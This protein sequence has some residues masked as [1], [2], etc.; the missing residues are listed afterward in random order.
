M[1]KPSINNSETIINLSKCNNNN[2]FNIINVNTSVGFSHAKIVSFTQSGLNQE[3]NKKTNQ[4]NFIVLTNVLKSL[5]DFMIFGVFDGHGENGHLISLQIKLFLNDYYDETK[6]YEYW[7]KIKHK[8]EDDKLDLDNLQILL[9]HGN[10]A[11]IRNCITHL[12]CKIKEDY[13][14]ISKESGSTLNLLFIIGCKEIISCNIGDSRSIAFDLKCLNGGKSLIEEQLTID[15]K[16]EAKEE[17][18]RISN[19]N[20]DVFRVCDDLGNYGPYRVFQKGTYYPGLAMSRSI[21]DFNY[22]EIGI[23]CDPDI[24]LHS[25]FKGDKK[26]LYNKQPNI[27]Y[28]KIFILA[29]DGIWDV[30]QINEINQFLLKNF[31]SFFD[32]IISTSFKNS[33]KNNVS[34]NRKMNENEKLKS[35]NDCCNLVNKFIYETNLRWERDGLS[36]DDITFLIII[37]Y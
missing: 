31:S 32:N 6:L 22:S 21:G 19:K 30:W 25:Y 23:S 7:K 5:Q 28:A 12:V 14:E 13:K 18:E 3:G 10:F 26:I 1:L 37:Y 36:R 34:N 24:S 11:Y 4:D 17:M 29:S 33:P 20:G 27:E 35:D 8:N 15:H 16:P 2:E 9:K